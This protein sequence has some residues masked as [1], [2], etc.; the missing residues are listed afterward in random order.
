MFKFYYPEIIYN[1]PSFW[2]SLF[3]TLIG[4]FLGFLGAFYL[5][6]I[7]QNRQIS[8]DK[9]KK[10]D[11]YKNRLSYFTLLIDNA[12][13]TTEKQ[14]DNFELLAQE[15]N[16]NPIIV[17]Q[18]NKPHTLELLGCKKTSNHLGYFTFT[19]ASCSKDH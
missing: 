19:D 4:T 16:K 15:I 11:D 5:V 17:F 7:G 12:L 13:K 14:I 18:N 9:K 6:N 2:S 8:I 1:E 3:I 10:I